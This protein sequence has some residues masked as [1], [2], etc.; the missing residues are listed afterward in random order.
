MLLIGV[1]AS[2]IVFYRLWISDNKFLAFMGLT[3]TLLA[4]VIGWAVNRVFIGIAKDIR[5]PRDNS[6]ELLAITKERFDKQ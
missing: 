1:G 4:F 5:V 6:D 2:V 3:I